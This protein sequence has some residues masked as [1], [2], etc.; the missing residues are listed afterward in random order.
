MDEAGRGQEASSSGTFH[1][2]TCH[3]LASGTPRARLVERAWTTRVRF[4]L[5][6]ASFT[7]RLLHSWYAVPAFYSM[8]SSNFCHK[9][10]TF[11]PSLSRRQIYI[12]RLTRQGPSDQVLV[13]RSET[14]LPGKGKPGGGQVGRCFGRFSKKLL[15]SNVSQVTRHRGDHRARERRKSNFIIL[16]R[17]V[18]FFKVPPTR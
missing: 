16:C 6:L 4:L 18:S 12:G 9:F 1:V 14:S 10:K 13:T 7:R 3:R 15:L 11:N 2:S 5:A 8:H 17:F